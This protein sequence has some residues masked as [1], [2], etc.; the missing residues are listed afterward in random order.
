VRRALI[1]GFL[2][3]ISTGRV[4]KPEVQEKLNRYRRECFRILWEAFRPDIMRAD[5]LA[6]TPGISG[7]QIA[8]EIATAVQHLA[9]QQLDLEERLNA[10]GRWAKGVEV[11]VEGVEGR[12]EALELS[13]GPRSLIDDEQAA[14]P[15]AARLSSVARATIAA[16]MGSSTP[17]SASRHIR[18]YGGKNTSRPWPG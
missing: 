1:P 13:I 10:A 18:T 7:A 9:R 2:F 16:F 17:A 5:D 3:G 8:Y 4:A 14:A 11:R 12:V 6:P 15:S